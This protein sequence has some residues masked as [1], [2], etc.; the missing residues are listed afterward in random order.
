MTPD[1]KT[2][3][4]L[5]L[6][7]HLQPNPTQKVTFELQENFSSSLLASPE[8]GEIFDEELEV[9]GWDADDEDFSEV[10]RQQRIEERKKRLG[11]GM[12]KKKDIKNSISLLESV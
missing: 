6:N 9:A 4:N 5:K 3:N 12:Q 1:I 2:S 7:F 8:L 11:D 10:L